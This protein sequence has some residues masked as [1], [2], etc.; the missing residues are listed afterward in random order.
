MALENPGLEV[1]DAIEAGVAWLER[2]K[3]TRLR[4]DRIPA[5]PVRFKYH[6]S[7]YDLVAVEDPSA[8][9]LWARFYE[10]ETNR[11]FMANRDGKKVYRLADV[12]RERRTGYSWYGPYAERLLEIDYPAWRKRFPHP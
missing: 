11:P 12:E 8:G 1:R 6:T 4:I 2:S 7:R 3:V 5:E 9:P 10:I